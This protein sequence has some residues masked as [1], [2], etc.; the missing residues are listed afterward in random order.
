MSCCRRGC[1]R[2]AHKVAVFNFGPNNDYQLFI[3][4][5]TREQSARV[6]ESL[7]VTD[8]PET[9]TCQAPIKQKDLYFSSEDLD[10]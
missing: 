2:P 9:A 4:C 10:V 3:P 7:S 1:A 6:L 5:V 8:G